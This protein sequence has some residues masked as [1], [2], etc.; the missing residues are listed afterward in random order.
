M[1]AQRTP[2]SP[3]RHHKHPPAFR[4]AARA[5]LLAAHRGA[6]SAGAA[7]SS[8]AALLACLPPDLLAAI[9]AHAAWPVSAWRPE[10]R[11]HVL[12]QVRDFEEEQLERGSNPYTSSYYD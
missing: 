8:G 10:M 12:D 5:L 2:W 4:Q 3:E 11:S 7:S 6:T 1:A 9:V